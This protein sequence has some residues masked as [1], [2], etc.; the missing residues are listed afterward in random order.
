MIPD[1]PGPFSLTSPNTESADIAT[2]ETQ[3][4]SRGYPIRT[5]GVYDADAAYI[6]SQFQRG[7]GI[8]QTGVVNEQTWVAAW[9]AP[10]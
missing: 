3:M 8:P 4:A 1:F 10:Q 6:C 9:T 7:L 5:D 2:W